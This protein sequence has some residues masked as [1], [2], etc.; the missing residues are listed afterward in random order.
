MGRARQRRVQD[1]PR[2]VGR[3]AP[4]EGVGA[5]EQLVGNHAESIEVGAVR[6][7]ITAQHLGS[8]VEKRARPLAV[9]RLD[10]VVINGQPEV[11]DLHLIV[12]DDDVPGLE[13]PMD[14]PVAVQVHERPERLH[15]EVDLHGERL[16]VSGLDD[17]ERVLLEIHREERHAILI[18]TIVE[19]AH[20]VGMPERGEKTKLPRERE[21][22]LSERRLRARRVQDPQPLER[23]HASGQTVERAIDRAHAA[24][25]QLVD[26]L[27][28]RVEQRR[29]RPLPVGHSGGPRGDA[30]QVAMPRAL[31]CVGR[32]GITSQTRE[33][34]GSGRFR[35]RDGAGAGHDVLRHGNGP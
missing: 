7:R 26:Q 27:I 14:D 21:P 35:L 33:R 32:G 19:D 18:E 15:E 29:R 1:V 6:D 28:A 13:I 16:A 3:V 25:A 5:D 31:Q 11:E 8:H 12:H 4:R 22:S 20:D 17:R 34:V 10:G 9:A 30:R 24:A 23:N 2:Q